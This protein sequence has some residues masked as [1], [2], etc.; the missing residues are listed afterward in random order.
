MSNPFDHIMSED[1]AEKVVSKPQKKDDLHISFSLNRQTL[2]RGIFVVVIVILG[3]M[4]FLNPFCS[5]ECDSGLESVTGNAILEKESADLKPASNEDSPTQEKIEKTETE[6]DEGE[7]EAKI[8]EAREEETP[9]DLP[10]V[11]NFAF[12]ITKVDYTEDDG[13]PVKIEGITFIM[14]NKWKD[15]KPKIIAYWYDGESSEAIRYKERATLNMK[16]IEK[17]KKLTVEI[18]EFDSKYFDPQQEKETIKLELYIDEELLDT[19]T[20]EI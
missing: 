18:N 15:F 1:S 16:E 13:R 11:G 19:A 7:E 8:E 3:L 4:V 10:F 9:E 14:Y 12:D 6:E 20:Y 17:G 2:E 5:G